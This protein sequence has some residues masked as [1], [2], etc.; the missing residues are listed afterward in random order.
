[1]VA[2]HNYWAEKMG[3]VVGLPRLSGRGYLDV[4]EWL[5][6]NGLPEDSFLEIGVIPNPFMPNFL[7]EADV[8]LFSNRCEGGTNLVAMECFACGVPT[9][10]SSYDG[11]G[12]PDLEEVYIHRDRARHKAEAARRFIQDWTWENQTRCLLEAVDFLF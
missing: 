3:N 11:W 7:R 2:W 6:A 10:L 8:A 9:I 5:C 12:E 4:G 1:M